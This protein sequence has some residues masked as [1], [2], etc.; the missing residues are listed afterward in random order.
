MSTPVQMTPPQASKKPV[1][2][3]QKEHAMLLQKEMIKRNY[4]ELAN[5]ILRDEIDPE[6][7]EKLDAIVAVANSI[8]PTA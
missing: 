1:P 4:H 3:A 5:F 2:P 7:V 8:T 6:I